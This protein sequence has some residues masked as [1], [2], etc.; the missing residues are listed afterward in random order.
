MSSVWRAILFTIH[1]IC[2][3]GCLHRDGCG[4][5]DA[6]CSTTLAGVWLLRLSTLSPISLTATRVY[7][8][9]G[10]FTT[11]AAN[12]PSLNANS[13]SAPFK[14]ALVSG[15]IYLADQT[16]ARV[17]F[18]PG[19]STTATRVYGTAG[20]FTITGNTGPTSTAFNN[21]AANVPEVFGDSTGIYVAD[22]GA[23]RVLFFP[24][25]S[26]TAT[27]VYG[28]AG[29]FNSGV[30]N[31]G[32]LSADSLFNPQGIYA[33]TTGVYIVDTNNHRVL[34]YPGTSTTAT[35]VYG[36]AGSFTSGNANQGGIS[37]NSLSSPRGIWVDSDGVYVADVGNNRVLFYPGTSTTATRV[38]GRGGDFTTNGSG[39]LADALNG[40]WYARTFGGFVYIADSG[41]NRVLE[42]QGTSTTA[43]RVWGQAGNLNNGSANL[44]GISA[45]SLSSPYGMEVDATGMYLA[46]WGN[47]RMLFFSR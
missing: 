5:A 26:T 21:T 30:S 13:L 3:A 34:F 28:Q 24:G 38:Y 6:T 32:G 25:T 9:A 14:P 42:F 43:T 22:I 18:Y 4:E 35:R 10:S 17:L 44:G 41:N 2:A 45:T 1:G 19:T 27:R 12:N 15:G 37:A 29:N 20:S 31:L 33:D 16:N 36:Q 11:G 8:Q 40:P 47:N 7:G 23:H 46:D 39:T